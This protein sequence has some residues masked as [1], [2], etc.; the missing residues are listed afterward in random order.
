MKTD[1]P[2]R[3]AAAC[4]TLAVHCALF[5]LLLGR[6]MLCAPDAN[7]AAEATALQVVWIQREV[8]SPQLVVTAPQ[9]AVSSAPSTSAPRR[10]RAS[11]PANAEDAPS[12]SPGAPAHR[13]ESTGYALDLTLPPASL[14]FNTDIMRKGPSTGTVQTNRMNLQLIDRSFGGTMQRMT[15][16]RTCGDLRAALQQHPESTMTI[17]Q[18][19]T[20]LGC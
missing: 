7:L 13:S 9:Q 15:K 10:R 12:G 1:R 18:T 14:E 20:R 2:L 4:A 5:A 6:P 8:A 17:L 11:A 16:A 3:V 19:M